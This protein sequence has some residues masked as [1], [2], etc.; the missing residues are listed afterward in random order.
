MAYPVHYIHESMRG[1]PQPG[2]RAE[3]G[4]QPMIG[5]RSQS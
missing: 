2:R 4:R 1:A 3:P 5:P